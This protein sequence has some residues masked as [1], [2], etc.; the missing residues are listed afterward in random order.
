MIVEVGYSAEG[1]KLA[2][3]ARWW[4]IESEGDVKTTITIDFHQAR[5]EITIENWVLT[6]R[7]TRQDTQKRVPKGTQRIVMTQSQASAQQHQNQ[8]HQQYQHQ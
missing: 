5:N 3:D 8:Q 2:E 1:S 7:P 4:L 6:D